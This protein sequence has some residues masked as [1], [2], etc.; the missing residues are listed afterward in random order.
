[1]HIKTNLSNVSKQLYDISQRYPNHEAIYCDGERYT[2]SELNSLASMLAKGLLRKGVKP[3]SHIGVAVQNSTEFV[4]IFY[5]ISRIGCVLVPINPSFTK[6]EAE[7][8]IKQ[9]DINVLFCDSLNYYADLCNAYPNID[10]KVSINFQHKDFVDFESIFMSLEKNEIIHKYNRDDLI[11][12][13]YTSGTTG[14]PKGAMLTHTGVLYTTKSAGKRMKI[15]ENDVFLL[16]NPV[17]HIF[18]ITFILRALICGGKLVIMKKYSVKEALR[19][20]EQEKVTVHPGVPTMFT[21]E[22]NS[23]YLNYFDVS[24]LRTGEVAAAS[25]P[26]EIIKRIRNEM[27]CNI[28]IAYGLTETSA[29]ASITSFNDDDFTRSET[30]GKP[31]DGT[32]IKIVNE[33]RIECKIGEVGEIA[34]RGPGVMKGY[35]K[36]PDE[37]SKVFDE[38]G[39][40]YTGDLGFKNESGYI[41]IVGRKSDVIITGGYN[42]YPKEIEELLHQYDGVSSCAVVGLPDDIYGE[43]VSACIVTKKGVNISEAN[44]SNYLQNKLVHYKVPRKFFFLKELPVTPS[45]KVSK[46]MLKNKLLK[47]LN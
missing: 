36:M 16:P 3:G 24:S 46:L 37:T 11:A 41:T 15:T 12:I 22:L 7:Y 35:Y 42:V 45:G 27:G 4:I 19:L 40:F 1:M 13:V 47:Q 5:A 17:F 43:V 33:K 44:I 28:L 25:C 21:L 34:V 8:I 23:E 38:E 10:L 26:V 9:S 30:V 32:D 2:Y 29:A 31:I 14:N 39:W 6:K 18:G 20:I